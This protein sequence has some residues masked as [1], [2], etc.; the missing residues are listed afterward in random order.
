M[1]QKAKLK[2]E[3][4]NA[5]SGG[6]P[7]SILWEIKNDIYKSNTTPPHV[8]IGGFLVDL[9]LGD[10]D[11]SITRESIIG[12]MKKP[13]NYFAEKIRLLKE[14]RALLARQKEANQDRTKR[15]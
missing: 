6:A 15:M 4:K 13:F 11:I 12:Y 3:Y 2:D 1:S 14:K 10:N 7:Y 9:V 8:K 5:E